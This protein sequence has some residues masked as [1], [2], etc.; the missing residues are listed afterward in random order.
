[1]D[2]KALAA[3]AFTLLVWSSAF[4]G[5]RAGLRAFTPG[6]LLLLRFLVA[7][8]TMAAYAAAIRAPLP[9]LRL[10]PR[11]GL[12][13]LMGITV[14]MTALTF[15]EEVVPAATAGF[16]VASSPVFTALLAGLFLG[17]RATARSLAG[18]LASLGGEALIAFG[19][20]HAGRIGGGV[21][22]VGL[23]ALAAAL[24]FVLQKP[25]LA[26]YPASHVTAWVTWSGTV[27]FFVFAPGLVSQLTAAPLAATLSV[28][29][30]GLMPAALGYVAWAYAMARTGTAR[31]TS[32]L[33]LNPILGAFVAWLWLG[34]RP[35]WNTWAGGFV[36]LAGVLVVQTA[37]AHPGT[38]PDTP[39]RRR[40]G[41]APAADPSGTAGA[42]G[43]SAR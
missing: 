35:A 16:I 19:G 33:Y 36:V 4:A 3:V 9:P 23:S 37:R 13:G 39:V 28:V 38:A 1:M 26:R 21:A 32:F 6:H 31:V 8:A 18:I 30:L 2:R 5:I 22:L 14:Y 27:P 12:V 43:R 29:Y 10:W 34:E 41:G 20:G 42:G 17:E 24:F 7:S 11:L 40:V 15:G 25:Y